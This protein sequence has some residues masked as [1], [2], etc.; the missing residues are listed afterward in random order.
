M[1]RLFSETSDATDMSTT[2][3][4]MGRN[5]AWSCKNVERN[6]GESSEKAGESKNQ[7]HEN[8]N[9]NNFRRNKTSR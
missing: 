3:Q 5:L 2:I 6:F 1:R 7:K 9:V 4:M 8:D